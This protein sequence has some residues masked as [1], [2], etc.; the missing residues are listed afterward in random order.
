MVG[1]NGP[2][3]TQ[4][5]QFLCIDIKL[6]LISFAL[7]LRRAIKSLVSI[8][9]MVSCSGFVAMIYVLLLVLE[10]DVVEFAVLLMFFKL[11]SRVLPTARAGV[12]RQRYAEGAVQDAVTSLSLGRNCRIAMATVTQP[13]RF[14]LAL[15]DHV[16]VIEDTL[17]SSEK[18]TVLRFR[19][20]KN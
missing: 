18:L 14:L 13:Y 9:P 20:R 6:E 11:F 17:S 4:I 16:R 5:F 15:V 10:V 3:Y 8:A 19:L 2:S 1:T 12:S 7:R